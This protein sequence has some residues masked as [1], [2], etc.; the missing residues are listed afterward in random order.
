MFIKREEKDLIVG[1]IYMD[2][3]I[4][5]STN[6]TLCKDFELVM[7]KWFEMS[8]LGEMMMFI[9]LQVRQDSSGILPHQGKYVNDVL[10]KFGFQD[11]KEASTPMAERPLLSSDPNGEPVDQT[12]YRSMIGSVSMRIQNVDHSSMRKCKCSECK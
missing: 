8:S 12:L 3:I 11:T 1:Q 10:E 7:K 5:G 6:E 9:G 4:F 2:D